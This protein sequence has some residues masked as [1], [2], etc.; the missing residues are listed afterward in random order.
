MSPARRR[1]LLH[2]LVPGLVAAGAASGAVALSVPEAQA[3]PVPAAV[4]R[5]LPAIAITRTGTGTFGHVVQVTPHLTS[6]VAGTRYY[7]QWLHGTTALSGA[8]KNGHLIVLTDS[9][10]TVRVR[11]TATAPGYSPRSQ[12]F[13]IARPAAVAVRRLSADVVAAAKL[14]AGSGIW[15]WNHN[16]RRWI[17]V[18]RSGTDAMYDMAHRQLEVYVAKGGAAKL[19]VPVRKVKCGLPD[20]GCLNWMTRGTLYTTPY[21]YG[22]T[23]TRG[24]RGDI[25]A[26]ATSQVGYRAVL[27]YYALHNTKYN[28]FAGVGGAWCSFFQAWVANRAGHGN[29]IP[30]HTN[31]WTGYYDRLVKYGTR[32]SAP[33]VGSYAL[34]TV[35]THFHHTQLITWVSA[36]KRVFKVIEGNWG[37]RV[38]RRTMYVGSTNMPQ[39]FYDPKGLPS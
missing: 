1:V 9:G 25:L 7:Y 14:P 17:Q 5:T 23:V 29:I 2:A 6:A 36:D 3:V 33:K 32:L 38:G 10:Q 27:G 11:V 15:Y 8:T 20:K 24:I 21:V 19:G 16:G 37:E 26:V 35:D 30:N 22:W 4:T 12:T 39:R 13:T 28:E 31:Y 34:V 18:R